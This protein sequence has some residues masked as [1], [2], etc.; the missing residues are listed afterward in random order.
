MRNEIILELESRDYDDLERSSCFDMVDQRLWR[1]FIVSRD[2]AKSV[3]S[4]DDS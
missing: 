2:I 1:N 3:R 4:R